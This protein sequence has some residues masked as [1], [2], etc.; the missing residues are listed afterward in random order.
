[1]EDDEEGSGAD[2]TPS[3]GTRQNKEAEALGPAD[4]R[5][6]KATAEGTTEKADMTNID[7]AGTYSTKGLHD[8]ETEDPEK[9][10]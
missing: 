6:K 5:P 8:G 9:V 3:P 10:A 4:D 2:T 1:M 7:S